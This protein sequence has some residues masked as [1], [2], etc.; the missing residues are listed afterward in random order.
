MKKTLLLLAL[1]IVSLCASAQWVRP[2]VK[3]TDMV[4]GEEFYLYNAEAG[5]FLRGIGSGA[6]YWGTRA[7]VQTSDPY[8]V[9]INPAIADNVTNPGACDWL[10]TD[11]GE[12]YILQMNKGGK[13][14]EIWYGVEDFATIWI[15]R[16]NNADANVN[17]FYN[18]KKNAN[19]TYAIS[20]SPKA[21]TLKDPDAIADIESQGRSVVVRGGEKLGVNTA[22]L[23][24][25]IEGANGEIS[26]DWS[27]VSQEDFE[28]IDFEGIDR[29]N[30]AMTLNA[31]I[32]SAKAEYP[33]VDFSA[34][35]AVYDNTASTLEELK[36]GLNAVETA[37]LE[38]KAQQASPENPKDM[39][40][41]IVNPNFD[42]KQ[43]TGW[44]GSSW[45][46]GGAEDECAERYNMNFDTYQDL[47]GLPNGIYKV[48]VNAM[49]RAGGIEDDWDSKDD[50]SKSYAKLYTKSGDDELTV[51]VTR[52]S[53]G[54][55][56]DGSFSISGT[57]NANG[58]YVPNTMQDFVRW[59][60]NMPDAFLNTI[61]APVENGELRIGMKKETQI[62]TNWVICDTWRLMYYGN[63]LESYKY[64]YNDLKQQIN[65]DMQ[66]QITEDT[67]YYKPGRQQYLDYI[68]KADAATTKEEVKEAALGLSEV[69]KG[70][71]ASIPAYAALQEKMDKINTTLS[72]TSLNGLIEIFADL[73]NADSEDASNDAIE[74]LKDAGVSE[75]MLVDVA[76]M[77][78]VATSG[79][80]YVEG[81]SCCKTAEEVE[82]Y[83]TKLQELYSYC[84]SESLQP[85]DNCDDM[86]VNP[87]FSDG[88][89]GWTNA[90]GNIYKS[91]NGAV[92]NVEVFQGV[93]DCYQIVEGVQ[94]GI[95][96]ISCQAFERPAGN[97]SYDGTEA[98]NVYI[99]MN[100]FKTPVMNIVADALPEDQAID[101]ENCQTTGS[102]GETVGTWPCDYLTEAGLVPNSMEGASYAFKAGRYTQTVY[103]IVEGGK[104]KIGIT[105]NGKAIPEWIL[106]ANFHF[107]YEGI[108]EESTE[109]LGESYVETA[110]AY[111]AAHSSEMSAPAIEAIENAIK[112][113]EDA[114]DAQERY[115]AIIALNKAVNDGDANIA[116][117]AEF[118]AASDAME[119]A[120]EEA[121][122]PSD[123]TMAKYY[124]LSGTDGSGMTT[125][126][127][128]E[129]AKK[130]NDVTTEFKLPAGWK[131]AS[132]DNP[133]D[134]TALVVNPSFEEGNLTGWTPVF[135]SGDTGVKEISNPTYTVN[136][137]DGSY[138]FNTW[139]G[140]APADGFGVNQKI[141]GL[142][143]GTYAITALIASDAGNTI[144]V[145]A[146]DES[147]DTQ[148]ETP[149]EEGVDATVVVVLA[150]GEDLVIGTKSATWYKCDNFR[151]TYYG[152]DAPTGIEEIA[153]SSSAA[154]A[155]I[156]TISGA[157]VSSL[158]KG[159]NI[160]KMAD[161]K[162]KKILI[163]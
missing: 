7:G 44:S 30:A 60:E 142:P 89:N 62:N 57:T 134:F 106:W 72:E 133:V 34:A 28:N 136:N 5:A 22:D 31:R 45:G 81:L 124:A 65:A 151:L 102:N 96:S 152:T 111:I 82:A 150:E 147:T 109:A 103:G 159:I 4:V 15:D 149:K 121:E 74:A 120:A 25:Y 20:I 114:E 43:Y 86:L 48:L 80:A 97:G 115:D 145:T 41:V 105:S 127:L 104:M 93:V 73:M 91:T 140:S 148:L 161:G 66:A 110:K 117:Y 11:D 128:K 112:A 162:V 63:S 119:N 19:G 49:Y 92:N 35:Q 123:E 79:D 51:N 10:D 38:W 156:Y 1:A 146:N 24:T 53:A 16:T 8:L 98:T 95:Y 3:T 58:L 77:V 70:A 130:M 154:T 27:F 87:T 137:A 32:Q 9:K 116:A 42:G 126:E 78:L 37:I 125:E 160:V 26:Y 90:G 21:T 88:F 163:K 14:D 18:V 40:N 68:A 2:E 153:T 56:E 108:T 36:A 6:P 155:G 50:P 47:K 61:Y 107:T 131:D 52:M 39:T 46:K 94:D 138:V 129:T 100:D 33:E 84:I 141:S 132:A 59:E 143:A 69:A 135:A 158:Q 101:H 118:I 17:C 13:W 54:A 71:L 85:G 67:P 64:W 55:T 144:S 99:Y 23:V 139:N 76:P 157:K 122:E 113:V 75:E 83:A 12:T 29:Y